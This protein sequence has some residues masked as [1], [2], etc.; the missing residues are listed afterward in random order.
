LLK[1]DKA[2]EEILGDGG[3]LKQFTEAVLERALQAE[4]TDH[5]GQ[6]LHIYSRKSV[7][8]ARIYL[9]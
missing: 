7:E 8:F 3:L 5:F 9:L 4:M 2:S 6:A 1:D